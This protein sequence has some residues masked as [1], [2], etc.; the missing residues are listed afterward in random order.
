M[1]H[2]FFGLFQS[3]LA[4]LETQARVLGWQ[5]NTDIYRTPKGWLIK[6][7]LAGVK[8]E[9]VTVT[10]HGNRLTVRGIRRDWCQE[11]GCRCYQMEIAYSQFERQIT[12]PADLE[13]S[14]IDA[15]HRHGM[16]LV[17]IHLEDESP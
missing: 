4:P 9:D 16:L 8:P 5:P 1:I 17:R 3:L 14:R 15:E 10:R 7:D 6:F 11:E 12:L 2:P 13:R